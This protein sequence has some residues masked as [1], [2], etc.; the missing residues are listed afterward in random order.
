MQALLPHA[1]DIW[2]MPCPRALDHSA[3]GDWTLAFRRDGAGEVVGIE[4]GCWL[5]RHIDYERVA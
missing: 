3:P 5:A 4:V 2:L 1:A